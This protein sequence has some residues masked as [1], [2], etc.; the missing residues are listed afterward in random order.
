MIL[1]SQ[2][3]AESTNEKAV[4]APLVLLLSR[5]A[6]GFAQSTVDQIVRTCDEQ[7]QLAQQ[8]GAAQ[9]RATSSSVANNE[10]LDQ[11]KAAFREMADKLLVSYVRL[12]SNTLSLM[13][14]KSVDSRDWLTSVEPKQV[15]AVMKRLVEDLVQTDSHVGMLYE[16]GVRKNRSS[17][18]GGSSRLSSRRLARHVVASSNPSASLTGSSRGIGTQFREANVAS[19]QNFISNWHN[20]LFADRVDYFGPIDF[21]KL[22]VLT[23]IIKVTLKVYF[24]SRSFPLKCALFTLACFSSARLC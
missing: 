6:L 3:F 24:S 20:K 9:Q 19:E 5:L 11:L 17:S 8:A 2:D 22:S 16:E 1:C 15:R 23:T 7:L 4:S 12:Q 18:G 14:R 21:T 13:V 10:M